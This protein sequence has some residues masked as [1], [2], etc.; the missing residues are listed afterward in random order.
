MKYIFRNY[1][2][3]DKET[4]TPVWYPHIQ[5]L[6]LIKSEPSKVFGG[7]GRG[8]MRYSSGQ[9]LYSE[10][11]NMKFSCPFNFNSFPFDSQKCCI[12]YRDLQGGN[13]NV[14][15]T[16]AIVTYGNKTTKDAPFELNDLPFP[17]QLEIDSLPTSKILESYNNQ[18]YTYTGMCFNIN[19]TT[20]GQLLSGYYYPTASFAF[21]STISY[22]I[23][24]DIVSIY[25]S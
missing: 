4:V 10:A 22:L 14:R 21:L 6:H 7:N 23:N 24:P 11:L 8:H 12:E 19:R 9:M 13:G 2:Q 3:V 16:R 25:S 17:F 5:F 15:L 1:L 20:R 18:T